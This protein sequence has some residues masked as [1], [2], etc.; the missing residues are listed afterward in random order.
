MIWLWLRVSALLQFL[1][2]SPLTHVI[3]HLCFLVYHA[4]LSHLSGIPTS[5]C[6][7]IVIQFLSIAVTILYYDFEI[8][9]CFP[10]QFHLYLGNVPRLPKPLLPV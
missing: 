8:I 6:I 9:Y 4:H 5:I 7:V 10:S 3:L 1:V 2:R